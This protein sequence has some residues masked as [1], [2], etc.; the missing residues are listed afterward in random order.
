MP[1][2]SD[3]RGSANVS[4]T[5]DIEDFCK[6]FDDAASNNQIQGESN[7]DSEN[8][9]ALE[10]GQSDSDDDSSSGGGS[11][12]SGNDDDEGS[13]GFLGVNFVVLGLSLVAGVA[14]LL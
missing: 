3:V 11:N 1:S 9:E 7:C 14:Q 12:G 8:E 4:S 13:A 10:G 6:F 2:L 5:T